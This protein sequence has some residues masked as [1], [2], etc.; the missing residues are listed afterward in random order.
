MKKNFVIFY[1]SYKPINITIA[2]IASTIVLGSKRLSN[3]LKEVY[4]WKIKKNNYLKKNLF[5]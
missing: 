5:L 4:L 2:Y 1:T 3:I